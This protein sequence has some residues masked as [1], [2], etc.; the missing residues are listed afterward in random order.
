MPRKNQRGKSS[1]Q[2]NDGRPLSQ[3]NT[4]SSSNSHPKSTQSGSSHE[5]TN[6]KS[7]KHTQGDT[8]ISYQQTTHTQQ[9][10]Q[11]QQLLIE[12][13]TEKQEAKLLLLQEQQ[14][15]GFA[16]SSSNVNV[17]NNNTNTPNTNTQTGTQPRRLVSNSFSP[18]LSWWQWIH[19]ERK[20]NALAFLLLSILTGGMLGFGIGTGHF[21]GCVP[22]TFALPDSIPIAVT[23]TGLYTNTC[24]SPWRTALASKIRASVA[25]EMTVGHSFVTISTGSTTAPA[26]MVERVGRVALGSVGTVLN[27]CSGGAF[28]AGLRLGSVN[29][30]IRSSRGYSRSSV[31]NHQHKQ[32]STSTTGSNDDV[33]LPWWM[34]GASWINHPMYTTNMNGHSTSSSSPNPTST[35]A[36]NG[37]LAVHGSVRDR[38]NPRAWYV[39]REMIM[40]E[41]GGYVHPDL[42]ILVPSPVGA[43]RGLGMVSDGYTHCQIRCGHDGDDNHSAANKR[44]Q[45]TVLLRIPASVQMTRSLAL[46]TLNPLLPLEVNKRAP[47]AELDDAALLVLL[48]AHERGRGQESRFQSYIATLPLLREV[49]NSNSNNSNSNHH[50]GG[51]GCGYAPS[52]RREALE[53][54]AALGV[55]YRGAD[56]DGW[57]AE[58]NRAAEFAE[59]VSNGLTKDYGAFLAHPGNTKGGGHNSGSGSS[60]SG[61]SSGSSSKARKEQDLRVVKK[62]VDWALCMV[63]SRATAGNAKF[64]SLRLVPMVDMINHDAMAGPFIEL[65]GTERIGK[66]VGVVYC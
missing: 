40:R 58:L 33:L 61:G 45:E 48:L 49:N 35:A 54:I 56:V 27:V 20:H 37:G 41:E 51:C 9:A 64:G 50:S 10:S 39:L 2:K 12:K 25:Y 19:V 28:Y 46:Q 38:S 6:S 42:G 29:I 44:R 24:H 18:E 4:P 23:N 21:T 34:N 5:R 14:R 36:G 47:L 26:G 59:R 30:G 66:C 3:T 62:L 7:N 8:R 22:L 11:Q 65:K 53:A 13:E 57:P 15:N 43:S 16:S 17:N 1:S 32:Q 63:T 31:A 60:G 52:H 55:G